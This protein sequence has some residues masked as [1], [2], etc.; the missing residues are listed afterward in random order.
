[1]HLGAPILTRSRSLFSVEEHAREGSNADLFGPFALEEPRSHVDQR[2]LAGPN[3]EFV[4]SGDTLAVEEGIDLHEVRFAP[5]LLQPKFPEERELLA[6]W[7]P[8]VQGQATGRQAERLILSH[9]SKIAGS[10]KDQDVVVLRSFVHGIR[11]LKACE[12]EVRRNLVNR[13]LAAVAE[14]L[15]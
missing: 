7:Q 13:D 2:L 15:G 10:G 9:A 14:E 5:R 4:C 12:P 6:G 3:D 1:M 8:G 11:D